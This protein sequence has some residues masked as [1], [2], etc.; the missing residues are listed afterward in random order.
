[1]L[2]ETLSSSSLKWKHRH[3]GNHCVGARWLAGWLAGSSSISRLHSLSLTHKVASSYA[4]QLFLSKIKKKKI[5][6]C[7]RREAGPSSMGAMW[8]LCH[9]CG[10]LRKDSL[11]IFT[12]S[13]SLSHLLF[14]GIALDWYA[15]F[16]TH[17]TFP[18]D[19]EWE[20]KKMLYKMREKSRMPWD[21]PGCQ[22]S[23]LYQRST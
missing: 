8:H 21:H 9:G 4:T 5:Y 13:L 7:R 17:S 23:T 20:E 6:K 15:S 1:M 14:R 11:F 12:L 3:R 19:V 18:S 22:S 10:C 16:M 2:K